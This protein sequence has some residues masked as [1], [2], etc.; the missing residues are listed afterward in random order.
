MTAHDDACE[1]LREVLAGGPVEEAEVHRLAIEHGMR[2]AFA[3]AAR[4]FVGVR[5]RRE[6][7]PTGKSTTLWFLLAD[8][9]SPDAEPA[10]V[11]A[12]PGAN[13]QIA[14]APDCSRASIYAREGMNAAGQYVI[15]EP[16]R[17]ATGAT[18]SASTG[19]LSPSSARSHGC[20]S[21][22]RHERARATR[23]A[24]RPHEEE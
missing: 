17:P 20:T 10:T 23:S 1:F 13:D 16:A 9:E 15:V 6:V 7:S 24:T 14:H 18:S 3:D 19:R 5:A 22:R 4:R 12:E 8:P 2:P 11:Q 21:G